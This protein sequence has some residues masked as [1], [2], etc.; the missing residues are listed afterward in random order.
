MVFTSITYYTHNRPAQLMITNS[1][2][3]SALHVN[4]TSM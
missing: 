4:A 3:A 1:H 2:S